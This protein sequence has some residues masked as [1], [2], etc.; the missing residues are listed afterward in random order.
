[1][2]KRDDLFQDEVNRG[3]DFAFDASVAAVFDDMITRSIP[4]YDEQQRMLVALARRYRAPGTDIHDL[5]CATGT[6]LIRLA[7]EWP[8]AGRLIGHDNSA[9]MLHRAGERIEAEGLAD[10][11]ELRL[12]D[13]ERPEALELAG[14]GL[15]LCCWTLQFVRPMQRE[16]LVRHVYDTLPGGGAL[17]VT[18]KVLSNSR[19]LDRDFI[20]F[21]YAFKSRSGYSSTEIHRKRQALENVLVPL[22]IDENRELF[23]CCGFEAVDTFFQWFNFV[24]FVCVKQPGGDAAAGSGR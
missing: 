1:M 7:R 24:G 21:H 20:D 9:D 2:M 22:R 5:G 18:E 23:R 10:R 19:E 15:V 8:D 4:F 16:A 12:S 6:T 17:L 13:L 11:I 14:A 3:G